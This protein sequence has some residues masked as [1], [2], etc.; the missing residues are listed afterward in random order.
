[1]KR[2]KSN[3]GKGGEETQTRV[4]I[5]GSVKPAAKSVKSESEQLDA[6]GPQE[7]PQGQ[8]PAPGLRLN[9]TVA[10]NRPGSSLSAA[11][12]LYS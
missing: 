4:S 10:K 5:P 8:E 1:M 6:T 9:E 2:R 3:G 12:C 7:P 11:S